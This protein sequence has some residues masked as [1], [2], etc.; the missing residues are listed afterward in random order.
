MVLQF[1]KSGTLTKA[2][3]QYAERKIAEIQ[4][5]LDNPSERHSKNN[6]QSKELMDARE[7]W[8]AIIQYDNYLKK[9]SK[10]LEVE[11]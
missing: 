4:E 11:K 5:M 3:R 9:E 10:K 1:E 6:K 8:D 2:S 7:D